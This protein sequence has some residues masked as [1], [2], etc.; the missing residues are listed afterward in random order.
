MHGLGNDFM[1]VD[2]IRQTVDLDHRQIR[3]LADRHFGVG[4][5]QLL[6]VEPASRDDVDFHYRIFNADGTEVEHCGNGARCF[7]LFI[8]E[9]GLSDKDTIPVDTASGVIQLTIQ[10][11]GRVQVDMGEPDFRP[12]AL[13]FNAESQ[14]ERYQLQINN[15]AITIGA[16]SMGNP[17][18]VTL[19]ENVDEVAVETL[20]A[21]IQS[22]P[23]FP[24][25]VN[26]G[27]MQVIDDQHIRL[28][29]YERGAGETLAC[30]TGACAAV[31]IGQHWGL[32]ASTVE[33]SLNGGQLT[34]EWPGP[35][36][37]MLMTGPATLVYEGQIDI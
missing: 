20:G 19:V 31:A 10:Q 8:R 12:A 32:L 26:A 5:D 18:A 17:H 25:R 13:P 4:F 6:L 21:A 34:I 1:V 3:H 11:D 27:F 37:S 29:V 30:G 24:N 16:V 35:G 33:V 2:A 15:Q 22:H 28:R 36:K 23:D 14:K 7:A 9:Q